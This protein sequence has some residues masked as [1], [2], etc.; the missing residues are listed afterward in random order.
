[1]KA[2]FCGIL[3]VLV[4]TGCGDLRYAREFELDEKTFDAEAMQMI[5]EDS[6]L[7][8]PKGARGLNFRYSPPIDPSFVARVEIPREA[9][10]SVLKQIEAIPN[11]TINT[12]GGPGEKV[13][14]WPPP[15]ESVIVD[16]QCHQSDG[17][18]FRA[19]LTEEDNRIVLYV[20]HAV[21]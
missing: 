20:Y 13:D 12:S 18:Y 15:R 11:Q 8:L 21:F 17:D 16:R 6:G 1:M 5:V 9:R 7:N 4:L 2:V 3:A 19:A 10:D 14:W